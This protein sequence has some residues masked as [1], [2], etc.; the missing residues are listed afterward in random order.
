MGIA[1]IDFFYEEYSRILDIQ[2]VTRLVD[3]AT[4]ILCVQLFNKSN[5]QSV[6]NNTGCQHRKCVKIQHICY[7]SVRST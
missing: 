6:E 3:G 4:H 1:S 7:K 2:E 5:A